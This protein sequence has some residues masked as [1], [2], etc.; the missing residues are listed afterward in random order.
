[1]SE[2]QLFRPGI[3]VRCADGECGEL[4]SLVVRLARGGRA[5][6]LPRGEF[7]FQIRLVENKLR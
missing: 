3:D 1:M 7:I 2:T 6:R 4:K 5:G